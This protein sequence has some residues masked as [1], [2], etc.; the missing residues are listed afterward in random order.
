M[1]TLSKPVVE[2]LPKG[3]DFLSLSQGVVLS[4]FFIF[5]V[6]N[7]KIFV[8]LPQNQYTL[9]LCFIHIFLD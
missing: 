8:L 6:N 1:D 4:F 2:L 5:S 9:E 7:Q 3:T